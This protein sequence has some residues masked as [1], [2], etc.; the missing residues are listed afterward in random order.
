M[1]ITVRAMASDSVLTCHGGR[2][3]VGREPLHLAFGCWSL[4]MAL[5]AFRGFFRA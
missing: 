4:G 1:S 5:G 3:F 2:W